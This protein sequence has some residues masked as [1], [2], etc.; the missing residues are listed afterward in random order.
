MSQPLI[1][2]D[3][4]FLNAEEVEEMQQKLTH[5]STFPLLFVFD[6]DSQTPGQETPAIVRNDQF[7]GCPQVVLVGH[8]YGHPNENADF[9]EYACSLMV[10]FATKHKIPL[11][12]V[13]RT[14]STV[15]FPKPDPRPDW[16]HVDYTFPG[17]VLLIYV[18]DSDGDTVLYNQIYTGEEI[19]EVTERIRVSPKAGRAVLF[20]N[21]IYHAA[22]VPINYKFRQIINM[23]FTALPFEIKE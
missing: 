19:S 17:Y 22:S 11:T 5:G 12:K 21:L 14:K 6:P 16:C 8:E 7:D 3:D 4:E 23:N 20:D 15:T 1:F 9:H 13:L 2:I 10:K 18:N